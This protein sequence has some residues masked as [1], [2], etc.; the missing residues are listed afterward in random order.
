MNKILPTK[1]CTNCNTEKNTSEFYRRNRGY[2]SWCRE[3]LKALSKQ[4][5]LDGRDRIS[6]IKYEQKN[7]HDRN[8]LKPRASPNKGKQ[9]VTIQHKISKAMYKNM[10]KRALYS[11]LDCTLT[12]DE[13]ETMVDDFCKKNYC[14]LSLKKHPFKPSI[15]RIDS[16]KGY[17]IDNVRICWLIENLCKNTFSEE[18]VIEFCKRKLG[19]L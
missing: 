9:T 7:G 10:K 13:G 4:R 6:K 18:D 14:E 5:V 3:C 16:S 8:N 19:L 17:S 11:N 15:D 1:T 2:T 12:F